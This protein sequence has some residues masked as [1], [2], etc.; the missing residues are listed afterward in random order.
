MALS[1]VLSITGLFAQ[2]GV[3]ILIAVILGWLLRLYWRPF[4]RHWAWS[5]L[6]LAVHAGAG[7]SAILVGAWWGAPVD[8]PLR[9]SLALFAG[10]AG[11]LQIAWLLLGT[12]ELASGQALPART[13]R[14]IILAV[15]LVGASL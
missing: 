2:S 3:A 14:W 4:L 5:W 12:A 10:I 1:T 9:F 6:A 11:Y 15:T 13:T 8:D 7:G